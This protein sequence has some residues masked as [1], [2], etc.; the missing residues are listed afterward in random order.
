M[1]QKKKRG[2][3]ALSMSA[4][5]YWRLTE[6]TKRGVLGPS[7]S[8]V[9]DLLVNWAADRHGIPRISRDEAVRRL[10]PPI[11]TNPGGARSATSG[12]FTF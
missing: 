11:K 10:K 4:E 6:L 3:R 2:R 12:H 7:L 5:S 1:A 8:Y 9:V